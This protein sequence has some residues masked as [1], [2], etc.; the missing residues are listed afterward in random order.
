M[1]TV[2]VL[3]AKNQLSRLIRTVRSGG[4]VVIANR[5]EPVA[6][7][8]AVES[9]TGASRGTAAAILELALAHRPS[10]RKRSTREIDRAIADERAA[11]D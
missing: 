8:T 3:E 7:L 5:G 11:W 4:Q 1:K 9:G 2:S 6:R 10:P